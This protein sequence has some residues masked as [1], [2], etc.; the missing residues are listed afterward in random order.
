MVEFAG[1]P[2]VLDH[3]Y[4][5]VSCF[6]ISCFLF[7]VSCFLILD[8][9]LAAFWPHFSDF[10]AT[11]EHAKKHDFLTWAK[12]DPGGCHNPPRAAERPERVGIRHRMWSSSRL[13]FLLG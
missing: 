8:C 4:F 2:G 12:I 10:G 6:N 5:L 3:L 1:P 13:V 11:R 9:P 7:H